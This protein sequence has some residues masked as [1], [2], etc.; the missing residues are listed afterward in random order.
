MGTVRVIDAGL[1]PVNL[2]N[3]RNFF[4]DIL[5]GDYAHDEA[6]GRS[7]ALDFLTWIQYNSPYMVIF[8]NR[9]NTC[10]Y[11][12]RSQRIM[13]SCKMDNSFSLSTA[14]SESGNWFRRGWRLGVPWEVLRDEPPVIPK[15]NGPCTWA[16]SNSN[17]RPTLTNTRPHP[18][19]KTR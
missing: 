18:P 11:S 9:N 13:P 10:M 12:N 8:R 19:R 17:N 15:I 6:A 4:L 7:S 5:G 1:F 3:M 14:I 16:V 2:T